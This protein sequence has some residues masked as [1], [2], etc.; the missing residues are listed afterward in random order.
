MY[1]V[2]VNGVVKDLGGFPFQFA[3]CPIK[4]VLTQTRHPLVTLPLHLTTK[5]TI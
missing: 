1:F 5:W 4:R 3:N 2:G